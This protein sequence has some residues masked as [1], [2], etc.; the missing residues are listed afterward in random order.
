M[1][2]VSDRLEA[3]IAGTDVDEEVQETEEIEETEK[4]VESVKDEVVEE[5]STETADIEDTDQEEDADDE[6]DTEGDAD[7][8]DQETSEE[9][10]DDE[11]EDTHEATEETD[12]EDTENDAKEETKEAVEPSYDY[13]GVDLKKFY[14]EVAEAKFT[15]NGREVEGFKDP[16]DLIRAQQMLHGYSDKMKVFKE[17][18]K[19]FK[20]LEERGITSDPDKFN[21]AMSLIDGDEEAI[22][23]VIKDRGMD[24]LEFD[25]DNVN[26]VSKNTLP[27]EERMLIEEVALQA[28]DLG[29]DDKFNTALSKDFDDASLDIFVNSKNEHIRNNLLAQLKDGTYDTVQNEVKRMEMLDYSNKLSGLNTI[30]K[31]NLAAS[32]LFATKEP[33]VPEEPAKV[34]DNSAEL[35]KAKAKELADAAEFKKKAAAKEKE[36]ADQRKKAASVSKKRVVK[37]KSKEVRPEELSGPAFRDAFRD[38]MMN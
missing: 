36:I 14:E 35:E 8:D 9:S 17:Y 5:E 10:D 1:S 18:K 4:E 32:K 25:L 6:E 16:Q 24:P 12:V 37:V 34:V 28:K 19:F 27:S 31:Y 30:E 20:P 7:E 21:L 29:I 38:M 13:K 3:M 15:A 11:E 26:Y 2:E 23:K 33:V 22:K